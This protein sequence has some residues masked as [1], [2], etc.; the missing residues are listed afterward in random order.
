M[1]TFTAEEK[2]LLKNYVTSTED[3][4]F[5]VKNLD[6]IVGAVYARYSRAKGTF[7]ETLLKEFVKEGIVDPKKA[8]ELI[9]RVLIAFG[10]DSVGELEGAHLSFERISMLATKEIEDRRIGGSPIE[11]STRYVVYDQKDENGQ[12]LYWRGKDVLEASYGAQ[13]VS[14]M[15][16]I[17]ETYAK[18]VEP[19]KRYFTNLK[20]LAEAEYDINGDGKKEKIADLTDER[21]IKA[22]TITYNTDVRTKS[23]DTLR[24][25]LP[26]STLTNVGL[27][28]NGRFFQGLISHL[29]STDIAE[30]Q[31]IGK[32][33]F[34]ACSEIIP[35]YVRRASRSEY[36]LS[37][38]NEMK[39]LACK[40]GLDSVSGQK[41]ESLHKINLI[42]IR[43]EDRKGPAPDAQ[44]VAAMLF[45]YA[46]TPFDELEKIA[47]NM[48]DAERLRVVK[49]YIGLR[50]TRRDRPGRAF[51]FGYPY[52]FELV[53]SWGVYKD[54]MRHRMNTQI[55]Q[56]FTP[57]LGFYLAPE[58]A[59]AGFEKETLECVARASELYELMR[60][61]D[62]TAAQYAVLHGNY[63]RWM[64][65]INDREAFHLLEL[66]TIPQGHP[67]YRAAAQEMH[68]LIAAR[69]EWKAAAMNYVDYNDYYWSRADSEAKQRVME[70][71]LDGIKP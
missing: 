48:S 24:H 64:L 53:T 51:E 31:E 28:G 9:A 62:P 63:V 4:V 25:M 68:R 65:G 16:H 38:R 5:A 60:K 36:A 66:R 46:G 22:F 50:R 49:T 55:R 20:P 52:T 29:Y 10:D 14:T 47:R 19:M 61:E 34:K 23:C 67:T 7:R 3:D 18:L 35:Q 57:R 21:D 56:L 41:P 12:W 43:P 39:N 42:V 71:A 27:F 69:S 1:P 45:A 6:G 32:K 58:I 54:L 11:Q 13:Y 44:M 15:D 37:V 17:F 8:D 2:A 33:A 59:E 40:L 70:R 30:T 26:L